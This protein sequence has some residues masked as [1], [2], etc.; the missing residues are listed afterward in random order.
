MKGIFIGIF[1][2]ILQFLAKF[3]IKFM[4]MDWFFFCFSFRR[5]YV[6]TPRGIHSETFGETPMHILKEFSKNFCNYSR[7]QFAKKILCKFPVAFIEESLDELSDSLRVTLGEITKEVIFS[8]KK[9]VAKKT[10]TNAVN[11]KVKK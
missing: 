2:E 5:I 6:R 9:A 11:K 4:D 8:Y 7:W 1:K 3:A 10:T